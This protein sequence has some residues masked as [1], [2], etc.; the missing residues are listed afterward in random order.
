M[1]FGI[2]VNNDMMQC[3]ICNKSSLF[4]PKLNTLKKTRKRKI[5][6]I[7]VEQEIFSS[8]LETRN[9]NS[10]LYEIEACETI[11]QCNVN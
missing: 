10:F 5:S 1:N 9:I 7:L 8:I 2:K 4:V 6:N 11:L 3:L